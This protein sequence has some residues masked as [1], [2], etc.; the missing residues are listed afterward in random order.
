M[1]FFLLATMETQFSTSMLA[2]VVVEV[3]VPDLE[4]VLFAGATA[5]DHRLAPL[6]LAPLEFVGCPA[7]LADILDVLQAVVVAEPDA[8]L[9]LLLI[10]E[11]L[12]HHVAAAAVVLVERVGVDVPDR[13]LV[14]A[15]RRPRA[16]LGDDG[17]PATSACP[18]SGPASSAAG[19]GRWGL[20][21]ARGALHPLL[22]GELQAA[23]AV[24]EAFLEGHHV[25]V[26]E[27]GHVEDDAADVLD[28]FDIG[29]LGRSRRAASRA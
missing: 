28:E 5:A 4:E 19:P 17:R 12:F 15:K 22:P 8:V 26:D 1:T 23:G 29:G 7:R 2:V 20:P 14:G 25:L 24:E 6:P 13:D 16:R 11:E 18:S 21:A 10:D 27:V 9:D 3:A